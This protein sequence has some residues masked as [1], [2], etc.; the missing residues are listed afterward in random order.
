MELPLPVR[1]LEET[2]AFASERVISEHLD[3]PPRV[4]INPGDGKGTDVEKRHEPRGRPESQH[5][6]KQAGDVWSAAVAFAP[7]KYRQN[8]IKSQY[9]PSTHAHGRLQ[10]FSDES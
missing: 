2:A 1:T 3:R 10:G 5:R 7:G 9:A 4:N 6:T 8:Q